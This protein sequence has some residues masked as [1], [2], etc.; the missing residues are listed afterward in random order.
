MEAMTPRPAWRKSSHSSSQGDDC[1]ELA[2]LNGVI[3][4]R[5][6]KDPDGPKLLMDAD[7]FAALVAALKR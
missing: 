7:E 5:D 6:S 1:V 4:V 2:D 3:G